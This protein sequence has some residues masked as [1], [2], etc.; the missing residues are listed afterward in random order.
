MAGTAAIPPLQHLR[1]EPYHPTRCFCRRSLLWVAV[2]YYR[3]QTPKV[4]NLA[5]LLLDLFFFS[6]FPGLT[7]S[8]LHDLRT[9]HL[10]HLTINLP[11]WFLVSCPALYPLPTLNRSYLPVTLAIV[12]PVQPPDLH[13]GALRACPSPWSPPTC[14][15]TPMPPPPLR[16]VDHQRPLETNPAARSARGLLTPATFPC[17]TPKIMTWSR[18]PMG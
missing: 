9:I 17:K 11:G 1:P 15:P 3:S 6:F 2:G 14:P 7:H 13:P 18:S 10:V 16:H 8:S 4:Y 5:S 12:T